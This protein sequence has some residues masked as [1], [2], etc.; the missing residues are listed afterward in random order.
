LDGDAFSDHEDAELVPLAEGF[1]GMDEGVLAGVAFGVVPEPAGAEFG[2]EIA[3]P[4][5]AGFGG[6]PDLDL[7]NGAE[8]DPGIGA[9][10]GLV[11]EGQ[12]EVA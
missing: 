9:G 11:F 3:A 12:F 7:G 10:D 5:A 8:V 2:A 1:V 4:L 6:V